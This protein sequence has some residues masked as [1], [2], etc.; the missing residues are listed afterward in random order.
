MPRTPVVRT[1]IPYP[2][3]AKTPDAQTDVE[4]LT[5]TD[6]K[7]TVSTTNKIRWRT[8]PVAGELVDEYYDSA[9]GLWCRV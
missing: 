2:R 7:Y 5:I 8:R 6:A 3:L 1:A 4:N 9:T